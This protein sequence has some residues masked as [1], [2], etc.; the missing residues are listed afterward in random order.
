MRTCLT[1]TCKINQQDIYTDERG[2]MSILQSI[3]S[4]KTVVL[5]STQYLSFIITILGAWGGVVVKVL[6]Y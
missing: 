5:L 1:E 6:R 3:I 4:Q 2:E